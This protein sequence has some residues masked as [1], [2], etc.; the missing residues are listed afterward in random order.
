MKVAASIAAIAA[1]LAFA[2][3]VAFAGPRAPS[4]VLRADVSL[5]DSLD[6][7]FARAALE[8]Q[9]GRATCLNLLTYV[10]APGRRAPRL[11][12]EAAGYP[13]VTSDGRTY[14][15]T[16]RRGLRFSDG[17]PVTPRSFTRAIL[18]AIESDEGRRTLRLILGMSY[19]PRDSTFLPEGVQVRGGELVIRLRRPAADFVSA[20]AS[21]SLCATPKERT[22]ARPA[23][24]PYFLDAAGEA[25]ALRRNRFYRGPRMPR[26][27]AIRFHDRVPNGT[28][29]WI[30]GREVPLAEHAVLA[31]RYGVN[32]RRYWAG[33]VAALTYLRLNSH[34][35]PRFADGRVRRALAYAVDRVA[36]ARTLGPAAGRPTDQHLIPGMTGFREAALY[37]LRGDPERA[38]AELGEPLELHTTCHRP[39][40]LA[41]ALQR[42]LGRSGIVLRLFH[43]AI[44]EGC[45]EQVEVR[46]MHAWQRDG[47]EFLRELA[48][49]QYQALPVRLRQIERADA[50]RGP[51]R[52]RALAAVDARLAGEPWY[53]L[54]LYVGRDRHFFSSRV[55]CVRFDPIYGLDVAA[56]CL[57]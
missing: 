7:S 28:A 33:S 38:R 48:R 24:G 12:P 37:P 17:K 10:P 11:V 29:D 9:I 47:A 57:R 16:I 3:A 44:P 13:R 39:C 19:V 6:P 23:A 54:P 31:R 20:V 46:S 1:G 27:D 34:Y 50:K 5:V 41:Q 49:D 18:R 30:P 40:P 56:L 45:N 32:R 53:L 15:F 26:L 35:F 4:A 52:T 21:P 55:G 43:C 36:L 2:A 42:A 25:I 51:G 8:R 22:E 14:T